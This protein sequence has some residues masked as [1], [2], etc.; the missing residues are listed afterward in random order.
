MEKSSL[1]CADPPEPQEPHEEIVDQ[2]AEEDKVVV[3]DHWDS[4]RAVVLTFL[5]NPKSVKDLT[6]SFFPSALHF[7]NGFHNK[8]NPFSSSF[9]LFLLYSFSKMSAHSSF[10]K[11]VHGINFLHKDLIF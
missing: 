4:F 6:F 1:G 9:L 7:C 8:P 5:L 3:K 2:S 11:V 10:T